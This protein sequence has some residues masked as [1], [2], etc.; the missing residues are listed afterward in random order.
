MAPDFVL[1]DHRVHDGL[2][3]A[4]QK[5]IREFYG[6]NPLQSPDYGRI[7][8]RRHFERLTAYLSCGTIVCG[9][10]ADATQLYIAPTLMTGVPENSPVMQEEIFGP[11]L[12]V[13]PFQTLGDALTS[14]HS[15]PTP[16]ALYL[17]T[18]D[19]ATQEQV[20]ASTRSGGV[21]L[22]DTL[23][24]MIGQELP[25]G[26]CGESGIGA[27]H[28]QASFDAFTHYR[29]VLRRSLAIDPRLRYPPPK[30]SLA[31]LK[32]AMRFLLGG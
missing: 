26:G 7:V 2:L 10:D 9:G 12:P 28:G 14:L 19:R 1:V 4:L 29:S 21:C 13:V 5:A 3:Q 32:R 23:T 17:F 24:H 20:L 25:F 27:Y 11:I 31:Q 15:R 30:I 22:N 18:P 16:L 6:A 8:H